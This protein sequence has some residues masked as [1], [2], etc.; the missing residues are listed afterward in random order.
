M[1][2]LLTQALDVFLH[3]DSHLDQW[4]V[5]Y[6]VWLYA[7]LFLVVFCETGL[8]VTPF[9]PGDSLLFATGALASRPGSPLEIGWVAVL[10]VFAGVLG[11]ALNYTIG[12]RLGPVVFSQD[13]SRLFNKA[14]LRRAQVFY[15]RYGG[16]AIVLARFVPIVRTFAPFVAGIGKMFYPRFAV[17]NIAGA[18]AWVLLFSIGGYWFGNIPT[19]KRNFQFVVL[20]IIALSIAPMVVEVLRERRRASVATDG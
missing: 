4:L 15:Q 7:I 8:V 9:L 12:Y 10:L 20:G 2:E 5:H 17:F 3:L 14:H 13:R 11:D 18:M 16:K 1:T 19:V 6:G